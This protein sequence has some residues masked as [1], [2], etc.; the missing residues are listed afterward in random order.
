MLSAHNG[1]SLQMSS[2]LSPALSLS[3]VGHK[4]SSV[5]LSL[6]MWFVLAETFPSS[7]RQRSSL[8]AVSCHRTAKHRLTAALVLSLTHIDDTFF[9]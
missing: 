1:V 3:H 6:H 7:V 5:R 9:H 4:A 2:R 8:T